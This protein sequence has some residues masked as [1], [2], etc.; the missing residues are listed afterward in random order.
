MTDESSG[1][2]SKF[3][4]IIVSDSFEGVSLVNRHRKVNDVVKDL[5]PFIHALSLKTWTPS[6]YN[7]KLSAGESF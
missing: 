4:V 6:Q 2:G 7:A 5:M 1:C 3:S